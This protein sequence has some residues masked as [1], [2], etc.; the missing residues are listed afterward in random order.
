MV[1]HQQ[2]GTR[3]GWRRFL[4][5]D[6]L[7]FDAAGVLHARATRATEQRFEHPTSHIDH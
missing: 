1:Y 5:I 4:A 7:W 6:P 2:E 3:I